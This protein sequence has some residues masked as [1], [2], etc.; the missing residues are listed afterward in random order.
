MRK[1]KRQKGEAYI[2][3]RGN[4]VPKKNVTS[5]KDCFNSCKFKCSMFFGDNE[6]QQIFKD[7]WALSDVEKNHFYASTTSRKM[8]EC[9][10]TDADISRRNFSYSY[11]FFHGDAKKRVCKD[12]YLSTL[13]ISQRRVSYFHEVKKTDTGVCTTGER[14]G[15]NIKRK[16]PDESKAVVRE[17]I[18]SFPR[19]E[20]HYCRASTKKEYLESTLS[21]KKMYEMYLAK[22]EGESHIPVK[23]SMYRHIFNHEYNI[24][25]HKPKKDRCDLCEEFRA[26]IQPSQELADRHRN[27]I[28]SKTATAEERARDRASTELIVCIDLQNVVALPRASVSNL[29]YKRKLNCYNLTAH[30]SKSKRGYCA[31]WTEALSGRA[32]NDLASATIMILKK[33]VEDH[34]AAENIVLWSDSCVPQNRNSILSL[35]LLKFLKENPHLKSIVQKYCEP[36]HSSIQEVDNLHSQIEKK[37]KVQEIYSPVKLVRVLIGLRENNPLR[38]IQLTKEHIMNYQAAVKKNGFNYSSIPYSKVK[39]IAYSKDNLYCVR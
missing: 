6:R 11:H 13:A 28:A 9:K 5:K 3:V 15:T 21:L 20:S 1:S 17:H 24:E 37:L 10:K 32:G 18:E 25:F 23:E 30:C 38:V 22:C 27:H 31:L 35:A 4:E 2:N 39:T 29:F 33:I 34:P 36:G 7:F 26:A 19:I 8:K 12:F 14:R 16:I